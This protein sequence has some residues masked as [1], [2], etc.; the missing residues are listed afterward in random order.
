MEGGRESVMEVMQILLKRERETGSY[1][2]LS[3]RYK[4]TVNIIEPIS[5]ASILHILFYLLGRKLRTPVKYEF[6]IN[7]TYF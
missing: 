1:Y 5:H 3:T 2:L 7:N 6:Q 4:I